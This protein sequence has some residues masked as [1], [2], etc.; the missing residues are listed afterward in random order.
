MTATDPAI[1]TIVA[2]HARHDLL[3]AALASLA[4]QS[5]GPGRYEVV[6]VDNS[7]D[8]AGAAAV[9]ARH[10]GRPW[11]RYLLEPRPGLSNARN[12]GAAAARAPLLHYM[13][14]D[15][16]AG[17]DLLER[18][19][20]AFDRLG[21]D[22]VGGRVEPVFPGPRPPWLDDALLGLLTV[23]DWG[24]ELRLCAEGEWLAGAN[25][26]FRRTALDAAGG[27]STALGRIG[28]GGTLLS[29]EE[30][31]LLARIAAAGGRIGYAPAAS[32]RHHIDPG[33]LTPGWFR[34]RIAWQAV[35]EFL[36]DPGRAT[37]AGPE[38]WRGLTWILSQ[39]PADQRNLHGLAQPTEDPARFAQQ[40][41]GIHKLTTALLGG[42][43][44]ADG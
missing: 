40:V 11:L 3:E 42:L 20:E 14:D 27:F 31:D 6:V 16:E 19:V 41:Y 4:A 28:G 13:D 15:A 23:V 22:A 21:A 5:L 29:N 38:A 32:V 35:S 9:A 26:A 8:Q 34:R 24:G 36:Q 17:P 37:A 2:T 7:P 33:R 12:I 1:T 30:T 43:R 10:A 39:L 25:I 44:D 18:L